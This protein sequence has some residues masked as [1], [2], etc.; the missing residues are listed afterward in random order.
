MAM[1]E[2]VNESGCFIEFPVFFLHFWN[3][4]RRTSWTGWTLPRAL[5]WLG[6]KSGECLS[7]CGHTCLPALLR[8]ATGE[9]IGEY[10]STINNLSSVI[11]EVN[12]ILPFVGF[13]RFRSFFV[14]F[15]TFVVSI[16]LVRYFRSAFCSINYCL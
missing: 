14:C 5:L 3:R 1:D 7:T 16:L 13:I 6:E 15:S 8:E 2:E 10:F 12:L 11:K 9:Q 4:T